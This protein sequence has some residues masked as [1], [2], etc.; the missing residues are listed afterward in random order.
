M[1]T[2]VAHPS[3]ATKPSVAL[4][5]RRYDHLFFSA[6]AL[7]MLA[8]VFVGFGEQSVAK[9]NLHVAIATFPSN[10]IASQT[11]PE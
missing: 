3:T 5:G 7:F 1:A 4:P 10:G 11:P 9:P 2:A 8:T 6:M